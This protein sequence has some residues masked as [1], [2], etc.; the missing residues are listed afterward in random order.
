MNEVIKVINERVSLRSYSEKEITN[1]HLDILL[2]CAIK[3]PTA[4]NQMLYSI[5]LI[6]DETTKERLSKTCNNQ[7]FI[8]KA[9]LIMIFLADHQKWMDYYSYE[10]TAD[11]A[12]MNDM[13]FEGPKES[14]LLLAIEDAMIAAQNVVIAAESLN[15][16][17]CYIGNII[18]H[19]EMHKELLNLSDFTFPIGML[20]L[21]YYPNNYK[22][23]YRERFNKKFV[24]FEERYKQLSKN[25]LKEMFCEKQKT[26]KENNLNNAQNFAQSFYAKKPGAK[27]SIEMARSVKVALKNWNGRK[28]NEIQD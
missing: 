6:R 4:G 28:I 12:K 11:Y 27:Y 10:G 7:T 3:A 16:G 24:V 20:T 13:K 1:D 19:Y 17:S 9:P 23:N 15:I 22:R 8:K 14:D 26:F 25:E 21:G 5:L 18:E 2:E